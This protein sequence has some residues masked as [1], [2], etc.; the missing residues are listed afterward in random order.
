MFGQFQ[1][2]P[3]RIAAGVLSWILAILLAF[4]FTLA[5]G[6]KLLSNPGMVQEFA[7]IGLGQWFRYLTGFLEVTGAIGLLIPKVRFWA[8]LQIAA[9]MLGATFTNIFVL[10]LPPLARL[11]SILMGLALVLAWLRRPQPL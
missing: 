3:A 7:Q 1:R 8:A 4:A 5:G 9:V 2:S 11:T 10:H 6:I